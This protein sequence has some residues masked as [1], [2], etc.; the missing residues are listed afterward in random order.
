[1]NS[2]IRTTLTAKE[3]AEYLGISY[4]LLLD[5]AKK[6][7][8]PHVRAGKRVL[9]RTSS[10]ENWMNEQEEQSINNDYEDR[11]SGSVRKIEI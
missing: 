10:L 3:A 2:S 5:L 9:F 4:H 8:V 6:S 7:M 11:T 1:M